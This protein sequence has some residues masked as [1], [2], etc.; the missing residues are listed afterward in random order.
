MSLL[1]FATPFDKTGKAIIQAIKTQF[2]DE[3]VDFCETASSLALKLSEHRND[4]KVA[5]LI[6][7]D[8]EELIDI[9]SMKKLFNRVPVML[10][11]PNRNRVVEAM[12]YRLR[13]RLMCHRDA[14]AMEAV[15][16]LGNIV[17]SLR[18]LKVS[19]IPDL[20]N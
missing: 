5:I 15:S 16:K 9:Y 2:P 13:P 17:K 6:P 14:G 3:S 8:E 11:L 19:S 10:V 4:E 7:A 12:G 20:P 18:A 1:L